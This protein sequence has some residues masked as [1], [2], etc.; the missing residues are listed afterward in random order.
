VL[1]RQHDG[2][3]LTLAQ[4]SQDNGHCTRF[5]E[6]CRV[7]TIPVAIRKTGRQLSVFVVGPKNLCH[8]RVHANK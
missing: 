4:P 7:S 1:L 2:F 5:C 6:A 8:Y 3:T